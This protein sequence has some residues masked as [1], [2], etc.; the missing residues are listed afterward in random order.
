[1]HG[2]SFRGCGMKRIVLVYFVRFVVFTALYL[3][4]C[5]KT[6]TIHMR[7]GT[8]FKGKIVRSD[9]TSIFLAEVEKCP[10][11]EQRG[12]PFK[13]CYREEVQ[14]PRQEIRDIDHPG[15]TSVWLG[16]LV[17]GLGAACATSLYTGKEEC[18]GSYEC[19]GENVGW[20][21]IGIPCACAAVVGV[22][23]GFGGLMTWDNSRKAARPPRPSGPKISPIALTDG[24]QAYYGVG[25]SW[26]W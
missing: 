3:A 26:S 5:S 15:A 20:A 21:F 25:V 7:D 22:I 23:T 2:C 24:E 14:I 19:I 4:G 13:V 16:F 8:G 12:R 9:E 11:K 1:M 17:A 6:A 10:S 18:T